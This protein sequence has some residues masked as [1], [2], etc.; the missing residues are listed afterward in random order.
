MG[1][2]GRAASGE[3][4]RQLQM[5]GHDLLAFVM[6]RQIEFNFTSFAISVRNLCRQQVRLG[7]EK[8]AMYRHYL[9]CSHYNILVIKFG[10]M[11][12]FVD[13]ARMSY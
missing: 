6:F 7:M 13:V 9:H 12:W 10:R 2:A 5:E 1:T 3:R 8:R 4:E 11:L